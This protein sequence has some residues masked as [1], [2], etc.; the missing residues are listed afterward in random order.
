VAAQEDW[1]VRGDWAV[2]EVGLVGRVG[3]EDPPAEVGEYWLA[4]GVVP[5][6]WSV[7]GGYLLVEE[8]HP[9]SSVGEVGWQA[10]EVYA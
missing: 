7:A 9:C 8:V 2:Q 10:A 6:C 4:E 5:E 1:V 3:Q